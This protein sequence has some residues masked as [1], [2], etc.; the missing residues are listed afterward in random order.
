M[1]TKRTAQHT[2]IAAAFAFSILATAF[3]TGCA[4]KKDGAKTDSEPAQKTEPCPVHADATPAQEPTPAPATAE[5]VATPAT[6][7]AAATA[8]P[9]P[10]PEVPPADAAVTPPAPEKAR[11][12]DDEWK[13]RT[14]WP[15]DAST[16][17]YEAE[18]YAKDKFLS[19]YLKGAVART[20]INPNAK[21]GVV[22]FD[23]GP[24]KTALN[25]V[26]KEDG[27]PAAHYF[28]QH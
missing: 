1:K 8:A 9:A 13:Q 3:L 23:R 11:W 7:H 19:L 15:Y 21:T 10:A 24:G 16:L 27:E 14:T 26:F 5:P 18:T 20:L 22:I 4:N 12:I 6:A 2:G 28:T 17:Q 25:V